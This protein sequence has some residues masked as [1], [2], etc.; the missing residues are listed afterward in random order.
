[1]IYVYYILLKVM[2]QVCGVFALGRNAPELSR[3]VYWGNI[4]APYCLWI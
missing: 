2:S 4:G 1:M 3:W